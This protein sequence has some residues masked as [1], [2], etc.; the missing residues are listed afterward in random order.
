MYVSD[1]EG[2]QWH[3]VKVSHDSKGQVQR[4]SDKKLPAKPVKHKNPMLGDVKKGKIQKNPMMNDMDFT[5]MSDDEDEAWGGGTWG[6]SR[7]RSRS[8]GRSVDMT[9]STDALVAPESKLKNTP[10]K[11]CC[12]I[13]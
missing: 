10:K 5:F 8:M 1:D 4:K 7:T 9:R 11:G 6:D 12:T 13:L 2:N 3:A